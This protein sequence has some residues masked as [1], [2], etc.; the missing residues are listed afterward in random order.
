[1]KKITV[2][3]QGKDAAGTVGALRSLGVVHVE[4][5]Q[6]PAGR[7][8]SLIRDDLNLLDQ[9]LEVI[10]K[11]EF[12]TGCEGTLAYRDVTDWKKICQHIVNVWRRLDQLQ[13]YS[14]ALSLNIA[15]W[16][17]WG[18]F[19]PQELRRLADRGVF[20]KLYKVPAKEMHGFPEGVITEK[21]RAKGNTVFFAAI[22]RS[23]FECPFK[24][25]ELPKMSI[26][27]MHKRLIEARRV[28]ESLTD[29]LRMRFC[30][31]WRLLEVKKALENE[32]KFQ[33]A[34]SGMGH[35]G[36]LAYLTGFAPADKEEALYSL[37][38]K[39]GL[40]LVISEP[41]EEDTV[42]TLMRNP[43]W[44]ELIR[45]V[46]RL[47]EV[48]PGYHELDISLPFLLFLSLFFGMIIGD[49]GY[50][51][52]Y[53][54]LTF[55]AQR[56]FGKRIKDRSVFFLFYLFSFCA[57]MWGFLA[58]TF[59]G[60]EWYLSAGFKAFAPI[61]NDIKFLQ[62][63][64]FFLGASHL[65]LAHT[66]QALVKFPSLK[67]LSD[68]GWICILW[69]AFFLAKVLI[70]GDVFP[71]FGKWLIYIGIGLVI[72]CSNPQ[73]N[74]FKTVLSGLAT[75]ALSL[76]NNFT[77]V[78]SY[79]RLFAVGLATVAIADTVNTLAAGM[80]K[81]LA[82]KLLILS[83]GHTINIIL[84]PMSV[85]VHGIRLNVLEFSGHAKVTWSGV[86][87]NPLKE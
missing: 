79:I 67:V 86:A 73:K 37:A 45:P 12:S 13:E 21:L 60:Q 29:D 68:L 85:L 63:F 69:A 41:S 8:V 11:A 9:A 61:L 82:L 7:E 40:G 6:P 14:R 65:T 81:N 35:S 78:V 76:M 48:V 50:G 28:I 3:A 33:Q 53:L 84:G 15:E 80:G 70:L 47:L 74:I 16:E 31:R 17:E 51:A 22:S 66:W 19:D 64:C 23:P 52:V 36:G 83:I 1:M 43:P 24:E 72:F 87:Y 44:V 26:T 75:V 55:L 56:K 32:L 38:K 10:S 2:I 62:A 30:Y 57:M 4:H 20:I 42:P 27:S 46:F 25:L 58:G 39:E 18:D 59:F 71:F 34:L 77:D 54:L 49:A 5:V